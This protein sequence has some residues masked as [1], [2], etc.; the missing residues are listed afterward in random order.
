MAG[1]QPDLVVRP[2]V[3]AKATYGVPEIAA[4]RPFKGSIWVSD[5]GTN[6]L[7]KCTPK[8]CTSEYSGF[9]EPQG[10]A[11]DRKGHVYVA[12]TANLRIVVLNGD[13]SLY[14]TLSDPNERPAGVAVAPNGTV[15]VTNICSLSCAGGNVVLYAPGATSPTCTATGLLYRFYFGGFDENGDL[16]VDGEDASGNAHVGEVVAGTCAVID[17]GIS[18]A[19]SFPGG[20]Q[21]GNADGLLNV[22]D[23]V[24]STIAQYKLPGLSL[25]KTVR[26]SGASDPVTFAFSKGDADLWVGDAGAGEANEFAFPAGG[27][28]IYTLGSGGFNEPVGVVAVPV[29]EY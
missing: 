24:S 6:T 25:V 26:L 5:V 15:G 10:L 21:V 7:Y 19:P 8:K 12:D 3:V 17:T 16:F 23:Q 11:A 2:G 14:E 20:I 13:G 28:P 9:E 1:A 4:G 22:G 27:S 29:G 18:P